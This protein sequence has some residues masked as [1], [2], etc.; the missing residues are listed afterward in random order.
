LL[1]ILILLLQ[2]IQVFLLIVSAQSPSASM[3]KAAT[4]RVLLREY[5]QLLHST[6]G[7]RFFNAIYEAGWLPPAVRN[8]LVVAT[9]DKQQ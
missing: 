4:K 9:R 8:R 5:R 6:A 2:F 1:A 3:I 7:F